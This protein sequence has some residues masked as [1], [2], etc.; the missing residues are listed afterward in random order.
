MYRDQVKTILPNTLVEYFSGRSQITKI[1]TQE[2]I[3]NEIRI[4]ELEKQVID[5]DISEPSMEEPALDQNDFSSIDPHETGS[6]L[7][8]VE[9]AQ[10]VSKQEKLEDDQILYSEKASNEVVHPDISE[11]HEKAL[12]LGDADI[13]PIVKELHKITVE[14]EG[15]D[16]TKS[17]TVED[18][19]I[20]GA[21]HSNDGALLDRLLE[22]LKDLIQIRKIKDYEGLSLSQEREKSLKNQFVINLISGK[23]ML[24]AGLNAEALD[25]IRR[26]R[27]ILNLIYGMDEENVPMIIGRLDKIIYQVEEMD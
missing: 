6:S 1:D 25:D 2:S 11:D 14:I 24:I 7:R 13:L 12:K 4:D 21:D 3:Q 20:L 5:S 19:S 22:S 10:L 8:S 15:M 9:E 18:D 17:L 23:T 16:F 27:K 26:A